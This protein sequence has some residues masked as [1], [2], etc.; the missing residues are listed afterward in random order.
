MIYAFWKSEFIPFEATNV[1]LA[2]ITIALKHLMHVME[3]FAPGAP[4]IFCGDFN[5]TPLSGNAA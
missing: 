5:S 3:E 1:R 2:Q 4:L